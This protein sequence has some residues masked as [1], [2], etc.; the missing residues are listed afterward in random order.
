MPKI[1]GRMDPITIGAV[2]LAVITGT[3]EALSSQ[4]WAGV[5]SLVGRPLRRRAAA[6]RDAAVARG[7]PSWPPCGRLRMISRGR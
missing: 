7:R 2:L 4:L 5:V 1:G 3:S 6:G